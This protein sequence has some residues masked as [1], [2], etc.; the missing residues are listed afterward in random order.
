MSRPSTRA[1]RRR[2]LTLARTTAFVFALLGATGAQPARADGAA[3]EAETPV[4]AAW[5]P[6]ARA[7][8]AE[9]DVARA[10]RA[11]AGA[12][13]CFIEHGA[14]C[15]FARVA[16]EALLGVVYFEAGDHARAAETLQRVVVER[17]DDAALWLA[18]AQSQRALENWPAA[19]AAFGQAEAH[20]E[21]RAAV[22]ALWAHAR[23][24][25]GDVFGP[26]LILQR[27]LAW[28]PADATLGRELTL[29]FARQGALG[30]AET[31]AEDLAAAATLPAADD[32]AAT[33]DEPSG[34]KASAGAK[35]RDDP[36]LW[37]FLAE[38]RL[39][40][41]DPRGAAQNLER[42]RLL[43]PDDPELMSRLAA[44]L[45]AAGQHHAAARLLARAARLDATQAA[46]AAEAARRAGDLGVALRLNRAVPD[47]A[48]RL[49]QR[50]ELLIAA[51]RPADALAAWDRTQ[52]KAKAGAAPPTLDDALRVRLGWAA[53]QIG[54]AE[55]AVTLLRGVHSDIG[56]RLLQVAR[57]CAARPGGC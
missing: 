18:L 23:R 53:L 16:Y 34:A 35:G 45:A 13:D 30:A 14:A 32:P 52:R 12:R 29:H 3:P 55:R 22:Y 1:A 6:L 49:R 42:A 41:H 31:A 33:A 25:G 19:D 10:G 2:L 17:P 43:R 24:A 57:T 54:D 39:D 21:H 11:L 48:A 4:R 44:A 15:G 37:R 40:A 38:A 47:P 9:G 56:R 51:D 50:V 27:G 5:L 26:V 28:H 46:A 36:A 7:A 20:G 8:L